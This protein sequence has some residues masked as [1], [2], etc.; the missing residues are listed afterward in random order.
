MLDRIKSGRR[1]EVGWV[2]DFFG[3]GFVKVSSGFV[4]FIDLVVV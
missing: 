2:V 4:F 1:R 3:R